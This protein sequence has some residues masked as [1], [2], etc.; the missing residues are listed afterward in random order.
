MSPSVFLSFDDTATN[1][2]IRNSKNDYNFMTFISKLFIENFSLRTFHSIV[3]IRR[4]LIF[5][6]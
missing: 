1:H 2:T 5:I 4:N 6:L 3:I